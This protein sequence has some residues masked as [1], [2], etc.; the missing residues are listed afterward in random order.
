LASASI[1]Q[2]RGKDA[3]TSRS[4]AYYAILDTF[5]HI[6]DTELWYKMIRRLADD[7]IARKHLVQGVVVSAC[8]PMAFSYI[9]YYPHTH[10]TLQRT[11]SRPLAHD[12]VDIVLS[13]ADRIARLIDDGD[14]HLLADDLEDIRYHVFY[15]REALRYHRPDFLPKPKVPWREARALLDVRRLPGI[16]AVS[17]PVIR[18]RELVSVGTGTSRRFPRGF[19]E[20]I[21]ADMTSGRVARSARLACPQLGSRDL[22]LPPRYNYRLVV[23]GDHAYIGT[24]EN[25]LIVVPLEGG[26]VRRLNESNGLPSNQVCS[27]ARAGDVIYAG[28]GFAYGG[29]LVAIDTQTLDVQTIVSSRRSVPRTPLDNLQESLLVELPM[30]SD[31]VRERMLFCVHTPESHAGLWQIRTDTHELMRLTR[32]ENLPRW[33]SRAAGQ[34]MLYAARD[35]SSDR[36]TANRFRPENH[37][38]E[39]FGFGRTAGEPAAAIPDST[40]TTGISA[41]PP[42][43]LHDGWLWTDQPF[44]R[45]SADATTRE[46]FPFLDKRPLERRVMPMRRRLFLWRDIRALDEDRLLV[47][48][49]QGVWLLMLEQEK[50]SQ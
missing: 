48:S 27:M 35:K 23:H 18:G 43:L 38:W 34:A 37:R 32:E 29:F 17:T 5:A 1:D 8:E 9:H 15:L 41:D 2:P 45:I 39:Q 12:D 11:Q 25:G 40:N 21:R 44:G 26:K 33:C 4:I 20:L 24:M 46:V 30:H 19:V 3:A 10:R 7:M 28:L 16:R 31:G 6:A 42:F 49:D 50:P 14:A 47:S 22:V 13:T 36:W